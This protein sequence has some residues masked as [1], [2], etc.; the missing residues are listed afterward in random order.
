MAKKKSKAFLDDGVQR[1]VLAAVA[2]GKIFSEA[3]TKCLDKYKEEHEASEKKEEGG[4]LG[5]LLKN[6][7]KS[8]EEFLKHL[9]KMP[10]EMVD[11]YL[12]EEEEEE[13]TKKEPPKQE[14]KKDKETKDSAEVEKETK[15]ETEKVENVTI[16]E[17]S[18]KARGKPP[19]KSAPSKKTRP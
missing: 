15:K 18:V 12:D 9:S 8:T 11:T 7:A 4:W 3:F 1:L 6:T 17:P 5:D 19:T 10:K 13:V 14:Q 16:P 2:G